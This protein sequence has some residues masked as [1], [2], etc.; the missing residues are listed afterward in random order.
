MSAEGSAKAFE[1]T[2]E[3][4]N[5]EYVSSHGTTLR[6]WFEAWQQVFIAE[7]LN[8]LDRGRHE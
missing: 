2:T 4:S 5:S 7:L 1:N 6:K 3:L 8:R